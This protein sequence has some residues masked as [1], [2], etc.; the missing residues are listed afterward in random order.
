MKNLFKARLR[1]GEPQIGLWL[2]LADANCAELL[3]NVGFDWLLLDGEHAPNDIR[4]LLSQLQSVAPYPS[5]PVIRPVVGDTTLIKQVL[6]IGAQTLL[7]PMVETA[8]QAQHLVRAVTYPP[9]GIRGG[10][11]AAPSHALLAGTF[12]RIT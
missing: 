7:V 6:D 10:G 1:S 4:S 12:C 2:G 8:S 9:S 11:L 3:A 5:Q